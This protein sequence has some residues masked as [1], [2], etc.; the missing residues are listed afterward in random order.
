M[1][2]FGSK[3]KGCWLYKALQQSQFVGMAACIY[4]KY[5]LLIYSVHSNSSRC[6]NNFVIPE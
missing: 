4:I 3:L 6:V 1:A 5:P 2:V